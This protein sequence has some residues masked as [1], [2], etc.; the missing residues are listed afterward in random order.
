VARF[1][2]LIDDVLKRSGGVDCDRMLGNICFAC[3]QLHYQL[4]FGW[5]AAP[6]VLGSCGKPPVQG[7]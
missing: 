4:P 5:F 6:L 1:Q 3:M 2:N 7:V